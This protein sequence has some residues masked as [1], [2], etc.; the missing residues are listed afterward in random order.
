MSI[1]RSLSFVVVAAIV[2]ASAIGC[3]SETAEH[4]ASKVTLAGKVAGGNGNV[5][6]KSFGG[7]TAG[8]QGLHVIAH[9]VHRPGD[10]GGLVDVPVAADG[11]F[12]LDVPK[13]SRW[14][15]TIDSA[16]DKSAMISFGTGGK[17]VLSVA[18]DAHGGVVDLGSVKI[19][20]GEAY[21]DIVIDG[22]LGLA[23][24]LAE[25]DEVIE[26]ANGAIAEARA[27]VA[28]AEKAAADAVAEANKAVS[29]A[30]AARKAAE[31]AAAAAAA[32]AG[33]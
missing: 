13:D 18:G 6:A 27:A 31:A 5:S 23:A 10:I 21:A 14:I 28:Q 16:G 15:V 1:V 30:E 33:H 2:S 25:A 3:A 7:V 26:Q 19:S 12:H 17:N 22:K 8:A 32:G 11:G 29:D 4:D 24:A 20:G 9:R